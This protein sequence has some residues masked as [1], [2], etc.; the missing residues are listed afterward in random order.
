MTGVIYIITLTF[1][2]FAGVNVIYITTHIIIPYFFN[3]YGW[4]LYYY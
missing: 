1:I 3:N 4:L 2:V